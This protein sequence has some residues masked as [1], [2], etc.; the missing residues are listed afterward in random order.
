MDAAMVPA[1]A[2]DLVPFIGDAADQVGVRP[3]DLADDE[4]RRADAAL[5]EQVEQPA[6]RL[7]HAPSIGLLQVRRA[8][9][10]RRR[11]DA[12]VL[13]DVK[14]QADD[15]HTQFDFTLLN[16]SPLRSFG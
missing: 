10:V 7:V 6:R 5:A 13:L 14:A 16:T 3:G 2:R 8:V 9:E 15:R 1:M 12:V 11:L 4:E